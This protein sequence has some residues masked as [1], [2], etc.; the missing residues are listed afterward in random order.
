MILSPSD[1]LEHSPGAVVDGAASEK[2]GRPDSLRSTHSLESLRALFIQRS[3]YDKDPWSGHMAFPGGGVDPT[4][5]TPLAA[6]LREVEEEV[7]LKLDPADLVGAIPE[8]RASARGQMLNLQ[9]YPFLFY[10]SREL[11][12]RPNEEV[13]NTVWV[14]M[15]LILDPSRHGRFMNHYK[16]KSVEMSCIEYQ[17]YRIWGMTYRMILNLIQLVEKHAK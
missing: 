12:L 15:D 13:A 1:S 14:P 9:V 2:G 16:D 17:G 7:G 3:A 5:A 6:A 4:D 10:R 8:I 11:E